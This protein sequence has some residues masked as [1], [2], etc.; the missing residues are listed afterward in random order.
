MPPSIG[1]LKLDDQLV[2][3]APGLLSVAGASW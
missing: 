2:L 3:A 1:A